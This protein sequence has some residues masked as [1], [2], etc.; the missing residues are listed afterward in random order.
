LRVTVESGV[1]EKA[2]SFASSAAS[3]EESLRSKKIEVGVEADRRD[4]PLIS[5]S[6]ATRCTDG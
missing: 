5:K 3:I 6:V 4:L 1:P 2:A